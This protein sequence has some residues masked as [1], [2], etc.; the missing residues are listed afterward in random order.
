MGDTCAAA[1][2]ASKKAKETGEPGDHA[3][4][5]HLHEQASKGAFKKGDAD[6]GKRHARL[7]RSHRSKG[8]DASSKE[9]N[10]D[11]PLLEWAKSH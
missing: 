1:D 11:N 7:A 3:R 4:A 8:T 10:E 5:A 9:S 6:V 2:K